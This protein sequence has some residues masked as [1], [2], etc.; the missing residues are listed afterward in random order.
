MD[1]VPQAILNKPVSFFADHWNIH[2]LQQSENLDVCQTAALR[3]NNETVFA[4]KH[5]R[6]YPEDTTT[7]YLPRE[8]SNVNEITS[9]IGAIVHALDL[10]GAVIRW[11]RADDPNL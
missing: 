9:L 2:F 10:S 3:L 4:L 7:I 11:Q 1:L 5:Y 6:G 8:V